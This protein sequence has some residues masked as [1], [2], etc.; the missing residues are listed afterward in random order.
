MSFTVEMPV[1]L[2]NKYA[3]LH[4]MKA[5]QVRSEWREAFFWV[6]KTKRLNQLD[7]LVDIIV[8]HEYK[9]GTRPDTVSCLPCYKAGQDGLIDAGIL[10]DDTPQYVNNVTFLPPEKSDRDA[11]TLYLTPS[12]P[13]I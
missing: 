2:E 9:K 1:V 11:L 7:Y 8:R 10:K 3:R 5:H 4:H 12:E 6:A 13:E